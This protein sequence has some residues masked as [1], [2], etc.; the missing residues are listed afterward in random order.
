MGQRAPVRLPLRKLVCPECF[1]ICLTA[2]ASIKSVDNEVF[3]YR[4]DGLIKI[5]YDPIPSAEF[6]FFSDCAEK[7][8]V[9]LNI[10]KPYVAFNMSRK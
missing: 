6:Y 9:L 1:Y 2:G 4:S 3:M 8:N 10:L 5:K 7:C